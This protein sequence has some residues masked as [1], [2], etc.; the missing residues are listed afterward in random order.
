MSTKS[1]VKSTSLIVQFSI[2]KIVI[3]FEKTLWVR[4]SHLKW[5]NFQVCI[6]LHRNHCQSQINELFAD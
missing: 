4:S 5:K 6:W 3:A 1:S 2:H